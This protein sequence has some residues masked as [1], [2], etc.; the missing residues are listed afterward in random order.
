MSWNC[1][2]SC[3]GLNLQRIKQ[4]FLENVLELKMLIWFAV[5]LVIINLLDFAPFITAAI[6]CGHLG[7]LEL[8]AIMVANTFASVTGH[9]VGIG[10]SAACDTLIS[11]IYGGKNLKPIGVVVQRGILILLLACFPCWAFY[12]NTKNILLL[13]GQDPDVARLADLCVLVNIPSLPA[14]FLYQLELRYL[15]SQG[16]IW[17][18][19]ITSM[20]ANISNAVLHY[21]LLFVLRIGVIG[22]AV[23]FTV[24]NIA[25]VISL[26]LY[27]WQRKL[28]VETWPGWSTESLNDW[29]SFLVLGIP[30]M[31]IICIIWWA[32]QLGIFLT[33]LVNLVELGGL[34]IT[35]QLMFLIHKIPDSIGIAAAIRVGNLLG[36]GET[37]QAKKSAK[38]S[39]F[40]TAFP[41]LLNVSLF[42]GL[43][44]FIASIFTSDKD[45]ISL[46]S[47]AMLICLMHYVFDSL[48]CIYGGL[49]RGI[50]KPEIGAIAFSIGYCLIFF[51]VG[52]PLMIV[53]KLGMKGFWIG[54]TACFI[55]IN[56]CYI[57]YFWRLNWH[58]VTEK[59]QERVGLKPIP[60][61]KPALFPGD[62]AV[63]SENIELQNYAALDS[64][65][66]EPELNNGPPSELSKYKCDQSLKRLII[67]RVLETI[68][69]VSVFLIGVI[70]RFTMKHP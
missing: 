43:R 65:S 48:S 46:I 29:K 17:P 37:E 44:N 69:V 53:V 63:P 55:C 33:G 50:G 9:C 31:M 5:P 35:Y 45:I 34:S 23:A 49:L 68:A 36:A 14:V 30:S 18:Q 32:Y 21:V 51:P 52:V 4:L 22:S 27:I 28:Y 10:L 70:I 38:L 11:Q 12:V 41:T 25:Q 42:L 16:I 47:Q 24:I 2:T 59:A 6:F 58:D 61:K 3:C 66:N 20:I 19:V 60:E 26:F 7:K 39:F 8:D 1:F 13:C 57:V 62:S 40:I 54:V 56:I 64:T 15:Q 67:R